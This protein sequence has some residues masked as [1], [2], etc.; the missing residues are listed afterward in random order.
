MLSVVEVF[1]REYA[2]V[3]INGTILS[4]LCVVCASYMTIRTRVRRS[5]LIFDNQR[6]RNMERH[7]KLSNTLFMKISLSLTCWIPATVTYTL[8]KWC[9]KCISRI[10]VLITI[11]LQLANSIVNSVVYCYRMPIFKEEL[12]RCF[13]KCKFNSPP[14]PRND[15]IGQPE[16]FDTRL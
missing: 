14:H 7:I 5:P 15:G 2:Y 1:S 16:Y 9:Q 12:K 6:R 13:E 8:P 10:L 11:V 3:P 4:S